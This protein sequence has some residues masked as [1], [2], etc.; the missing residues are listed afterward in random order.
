MTT[1]A[2]DRAAD[3]ARFHADLDSAPRARTGASSNMWTAAIAGADSTLASTLRAFLQQ[4]GLI[5]SVVEWDLRKGLDRPDQ[6]AASADVVVLSLDGASGAALAFASDLRRSNPVVKIIAYSPD[7]HPDSQLLMNAMRSGVQEFLPSPLTAAGVHEALTRFQDGTA[8]AV[9]EAQQKLIIVMG[10]KGGV[11]SSTI[12]V[13]LAVQLVHMT[14]RR[15]VLLDFA[16]P[17]GHAGL[18]LDL[19]SRYS[20]RDATESIDRLDSHFFAGLLSRHKTGLEVLH[21]ISHPEE[22]HQISNH[23]LPSIVNVAQ[24]SFDYVVMD[25]GS[26]YTLAWISEAVLRLAR[27]TLLVAE[28][29]VPALWTL[30]RHMSGLTA[31]GFNSDQIRIVINR[32]TRGDDEALKSLEKKLRRPV[33][34]RIPN[35][36]RQVSESVNMGTPLSKDQSNPLVSQIQ[37]LILQLGISRAEPS[38]QAR[39]DGLGGMFSSFM[40]KK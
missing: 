38:L 40:K 13:N 25:Y 29:N 31:V 17:I 37:N 4:T 2:E 21:G 33:F 22:W 28:A 19:H 1:R 10:S 6:K 11:G 32:W 14:E 7:R 20:L 39:R 9:K 18:M 24:S 15:V 36:F 30:E 34:S 5:G 3:S 16:R 35:D 23:A 27:T 26:I 8:S 12:A